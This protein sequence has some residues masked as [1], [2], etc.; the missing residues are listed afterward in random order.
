MINAA[1]SESRGAIL[2]AV[3]A[4][5]ERIARLDP[6]DAAT[7]IVFSDRARVEA[8]ATSDRD[9]LMQILA[10]VAIEPHGTRYAPA[11][12]LQRTQCFVIIRLTSPSSWWL[13]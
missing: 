4:A 8:E 2:R 3:A 7:L 12:K 5:T 9:R 1:T 10:E 11:L 6:A 13:S